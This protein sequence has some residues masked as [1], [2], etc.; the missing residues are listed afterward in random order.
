MD[1][2][3]RDSIRAG[4]SETAKKINSEEYLELI[5]RFAEK[6]LGGGAG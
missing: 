4:I 6:L 3:K 1:N 5:L 2:Q